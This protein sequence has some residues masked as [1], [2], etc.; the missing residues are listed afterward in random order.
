[1]EFLGWYSWYIYRV[2][3]CLSEPWGVC[4][5]TPISSILSYKHFMGVFDGQGELMN[6]LLQTFYKL[7]NTYQH[8]L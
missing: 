6:S 4:I 8:H 1:M 2:L 5:S 7:I 3:S